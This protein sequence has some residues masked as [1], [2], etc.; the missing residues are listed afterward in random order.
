[1]ANA[2]E[3]VYDISDSNRLR[4]E[5]EERR[6]ERSAQFRQQ[7][8]NRRQFRE[9]FMQQ[10]G[11]LDEESKVEPAAPRVQ[12]T[13]RRSRPQT[14]PIS[15]REFATVR[16]RSKL[17]RDL[18]KQEAAV[19]RKQE[20]KEKQFAALRARANQYIWNFNYPVQKELDESDYMFRYRKQLNS[21]RGINDVETKIL[22]NTAL[23]GSKY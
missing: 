1:M 12:A 20:L 11:A 13:P 23:A 9:Q 8:A 15:A 3:E 16:A 21:K 18:E 10:R 22:R 2:E 5:V 19:K 17:A 4:Q 14:T 7:L 6:Q